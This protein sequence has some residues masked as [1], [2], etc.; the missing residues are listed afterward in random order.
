MSVRVEVAQLAVAAPD[1]QSLYEVLRVKRNASQ[2][3]I[4]MAYRTLAKLHH[5]ETRTAAY[6]LNLTVDSRG[7]WIPAS[8]S[9]YRNPG[10]ERFYQAR[11]WET[12]QC[13]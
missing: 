3:E 4:K 8:V 2:V 7:R 6:D 12:D 9:G 5:P 13:G 10:M 1:R 11:R